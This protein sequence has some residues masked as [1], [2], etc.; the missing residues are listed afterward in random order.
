MFYDAECDSAH[1]DGIDPDAFS[2]R[3]ATLSG[4][5]SSIATH[6]AYRAGS[7]GLAVGAVG[8]G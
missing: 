5:S 3:V 1:S 4:A 2:C 6:A 7:A 8:G